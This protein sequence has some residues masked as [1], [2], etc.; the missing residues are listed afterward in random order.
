[1]QTVIE[2]TAMENRW[3]SLQNRPGTNRDTIVFYKDMRFWL[4]VLMLAAFFAFTLVRFP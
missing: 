4:I 2:A 3:K 1:V